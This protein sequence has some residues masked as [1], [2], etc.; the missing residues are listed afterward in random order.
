[1]SIS[2]SGFGILFTYSVNDEETAA[3]YNEGDAAI[4]DV[5][6]SFGAWPNI[7]VIVV[8]KLNDDSL[9]VLVGE[10]TREAASLEVV[11]IVLHSPKHFAVKSESSAD[12]RI[13][14]VDSCDAVSDTCF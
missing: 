14:P 5:L 3:K 10:Q 6:F 11:E 2:A 9:L 7:E 4:H 8:A 13:L 1:M 12:D